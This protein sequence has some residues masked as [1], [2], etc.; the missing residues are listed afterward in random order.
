MNPTVNGA[1]PLV[2]VPANSA[3]GGSGSLTTTYPLRVRV[4]LPP[5][6][7][8]VND[9]VYT[10]TLLYVCDGFCSLLPI[11]SPKSHDHPLLLPDD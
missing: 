7:V 6:P 9:T 11:P 10:P 2:G 1:T 8:T 4:L 5:G 3:L